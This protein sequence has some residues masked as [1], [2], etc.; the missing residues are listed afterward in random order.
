MVCSSTTMSQSQTNSSED[1]S[2]SPPVPSLQPAGPKSTPPQR[3]T[4][5]E[6]QAPSLGRCMAQA[7]T[8]LP[9]CLGLPS[10]S[11]ARIPVDSPASSY[12]SAR[13]T[14]PPIGKWTVSSLRQALT[15]SDVQPSCKLNKAELY[16][17]YT[18]L[19]LTYLSRESTPTPKKGKIKINLQI[20]LVGLHHPPPA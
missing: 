7:A 8:H 20:C 15:K 11:P 5:I 12:H 17:L 9:R 1:E 4:R 3:G 6:P 16:D 19:Q 10:P 14:I 13:Q 18:N 2:N